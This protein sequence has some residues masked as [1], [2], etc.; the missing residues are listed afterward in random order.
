[1]E[2]SAETY[3]KASVLRLQDEL[4][5][6][7]VATLNK[8]VE[9]QVAD[10]EP[11]DMVLDFEKVSSIDSAGLEC[12][13]DIRDQLAEILCTF[14]LVNL[15]EHLLKILEITRLNEELDVCKDIAEAVRTLQ[16]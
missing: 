5:E 1:M 14:R 9:R 3:G 11:T 12:L 10:L 7:S 13:L 2:I 15:D 6:D 16:P 4:S 8:A